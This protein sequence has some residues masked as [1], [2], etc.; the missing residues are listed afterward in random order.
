MLIESTA[1][2]SLKEIVAKPVSFDNAIIEN[3]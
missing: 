2:Y 3:V 1:G